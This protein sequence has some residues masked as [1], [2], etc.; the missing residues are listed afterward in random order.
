MCALPWGGPCI[1]HHGPGQQALK[2]AAFSL[3]LFGRGLR[4]FVLG[5]RT[6]VLGTGQEPG[7]AGGFP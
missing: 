3:S 6:P 5:T 1:S 7:R 2:A 4:A